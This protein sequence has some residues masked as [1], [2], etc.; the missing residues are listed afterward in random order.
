MARIPVYQRQVGVNAGPATQINTSTQTTDQQMFQQGVNDLSSGLIRYQ[1]QK[2]DSELQDASLAGKEAVQNIVTNAQQ[3]QGKNAIGS[4]QNALKAFDD[5]VSQLQAPSNRKEDWDRQVKA[6]RLQLAGLVS[7]HESQQSEQYRAGQFKSQVELGI[8]GAG[9]SYSDASAYKLNNASTIHAIQSWGESQGWSDEQVK[10]A[11]TDYTQK[12]SQAAVNA[13]IGSMQKGMLNSDGTLSSFNGQIDADQL[14]TAVVGQESGGRQFG[15]DGLSLR[16]KKGAIG[17]AQ[18]MPGTAPE[19]AKLAGLPW[20]EGRYHNDPQY[21]L[22]LGKAYL[23]KQLSDFGGNQALA[24]AAYNAGPGIV[25]DWING[26]N[27]TGK[28][29]SL[30][31]TGDPRTGAITNDDF[32]RS[33][34]YAETQDYV[35]NILSNVPSIPQASSISAITSTPY[36]KQL[37]PEAQSQALSG[38]ASMLSKQRAA[39]Q[40]TLNGVVNDTSTA[41]R[42][43]ETPAVMPDR[44]QLISTYGLL[45]GEQLFNKLQEDYQFG[46]NVKMVKG[47]NPYQQQ[48]LLDQQKPS[49]GPDY[50]E[51]KANYD[52]LQQAVASVNAARTSDPIAFGMKEGVVSP[53]DFTSQETI[54]QGLSARLGQAEQVS[55]AYGTPPVLFNKQ[56]A[57]QFSTM[58]SQLPPDSAISLLQSAG[59]SL[60]P[61]GISMLQSQIGENNPTYGALAGILATPD[62]YKNTKTGVGSYITY[63]LTVDKYNASDRIIRGYRALNPSKEDKAAGVTPVTIPSDQKMEEA[64]NERVGDSFV[65]SAQERQK[66]YNLFKSAYAG[67]MLYSPDVKAD[68]RSGASRGVLDA[69]ADKAMLY[70]TGGVLKYS[71]KDVVAPYGMGDDAFKEKMDSARAEA[72]KG[73]G[74]YSNFSPV[75]LPSGRYGFRVGNRLATKDGQLL[76][77]EIN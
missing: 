1:V 44:N 14:M 57:K 31:K 29:K 38:Y 24:L 68:D 55:N 40:A 54:Q 61:A 17:V 73:M 53:I 50:T 36:F 69:V 32:V 16:S 10:A 5:Q 23:K 26:T 56:E 12:A 75:K 71:G 58:L 27:K 63:P 11:V 8:A 45:Q 13:Q 60:S 52:H 74:S 18:I 15:A 66:A 65:M 35:T 9:Q 19:A 64:F 72:F 20:D 70:A 49:P 51:R 30:I 48:Q 47:M 6:M 59:R 67:E 4:T 21:N 43:G 2:G 22:E 41:L 37:S 28:N 76:T 77:V 25:S 42:N 3:L 62:N 33:I 7:N 46:Q 39:S 34:P